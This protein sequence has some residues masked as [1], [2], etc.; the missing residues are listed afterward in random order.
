MRRLLFACAGGLAALTALMIAGSSVASSDE[1]PA[2]VELFTS[3]GCSSCPPA[4]Q[5][6][7]ELARDPS[8]IVMSLPVDYWD[9]LG[10]KDTLAL[11][12][13]TNRQ[14]A[15][16]RTR[17]DREVY[18][19]QVV[20]NGSAHV[21]G[22]DKAAIE[23]AIVRTGKQSGTLSLP[24]TLAVANGQISVTVPAAKDGA[25]KGEVEFSRVGQ[26]HS[27]AAF[28]AALAFNGSTRMKVVEVDPVFNDVMG[29]T[30]IACAPLTSTL[31]FNDRGAG[32][33]TVEVSVEVL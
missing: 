22:S 15:Y 17:G 28:N 18:T 20:V 33:Y 2:V 29:A 21:L 5:L 1:P 13:H 10:W 25:A 4:D 26:G 23:S 12:G 11:P 27:A 30:D 7:G 14:R 6:A 32:A 16:A 19:P 3:Q 31:V 9:Y 8:V 24:L